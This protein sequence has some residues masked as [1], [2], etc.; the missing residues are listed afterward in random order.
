MAATTC[1]SSAGRWSA[2]TTRA[3]TCTRRSCPTR[4]AATFAFYR[5]GLEAAGARLRNYVE[6]QASGI[7]DEPATARALA[8]FVLRGLDCGAVSPDE[9]TTAS[10]LDAPA[11]AVLAHRTTET[12]G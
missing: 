4:Y 11:L 2:A 5:G 1:D 12:E 8:D 10:G 7:L 3:G 6:R 9:V